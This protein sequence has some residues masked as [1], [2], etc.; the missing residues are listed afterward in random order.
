MSMDLFILRHAIAEERS[1]RWSDDS[2]R[3]LTEEGAEKMRE[4]AKGMKVMELEFDLI[5]SSPYVRAK[6]TADIVA[7]VYDAKVH[8]SKHLES[9]GNAKTLIQELNSEYQSKTSVLLV[10]HEPDLG[11]LVSLLCSGKEEFSVTFK[12]AGLCKLSVA[13]LIHGKCASLEWLMT[14]KQIRYFEK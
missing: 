10:G 2:K 5:L 8:T 7:D 4:V 3:P 6:E 12:K 13:K 1:P 14:P 9:G 11:H